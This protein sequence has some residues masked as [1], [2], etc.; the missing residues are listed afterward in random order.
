MFFHSVHSVHFVHGVQG[1]HLVNRIE[2]GV[3]ASGSILAEPWA[4]VGIGVQ[5]E[6]Y[7]RVPQC[8]TDYLYMDF[9]LCTDSRPSLYRAFLATIQTAEWSR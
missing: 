6:I 9:Q 8:F 5:G 1:V 7:P 4:Q 3:K 2:G